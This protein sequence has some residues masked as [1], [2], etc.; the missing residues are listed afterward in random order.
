MS[1]PCV[2]QQLNARSSVPSQYRMLDVFGGGTPLGIATLCVHSSSS[3][4]FVCH[5]QERLL[6]VSSAVRPL[7]L[8]CSAEWTP[9]KAAALKGHGSGQ[10][11][12]V[13]KLW[14]EFFS[15]PSQWWDHR[16]EKVR[17][18]QNSGGLSTCC[19]FQ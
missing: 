4:S 8:L 6:F 2:Q 13:E 17:I 5:A 3:S 12:I 18:D 9:T 16:S 14:R 19:D 15:D 10:K 1:S 11:L 7:A